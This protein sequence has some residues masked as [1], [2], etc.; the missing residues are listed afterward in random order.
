MQEEEEQDRSLKERFS[1]TLEQKMVHN[2][3]T[4][5]EEFMKLP[6][7]VFANLIRNPFIRQEVIKELPFDKTATRQELD[8]WLDLCEKDQFLEYTSK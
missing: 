7:Y 8:Q 6:F 1:E 3:L 5:N 2:M 4:R